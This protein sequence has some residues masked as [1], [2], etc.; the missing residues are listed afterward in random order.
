MSCSNV[1]R[2]HA[3]INHNRRIDPV[4]RNARERGQ[5][6]STGRKTDKPAGWSVSAIVG[7]RLDVAFLVDDAITISMA[8]I[9]ISFAYNRNDAVYLI[10]YSR[11]S[12]PV[13]GVA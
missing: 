8:V 13:E 5:G 1:S 6:S 11:L 3:L 2:A 4:T 7:M 12:V 10:R 9:E